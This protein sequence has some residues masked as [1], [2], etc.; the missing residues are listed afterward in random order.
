MV[1]AL[2]AVP[3]GSIEDLEKYKESLYE[4]VAC[5]SE[6]IGRI[7]QSDIVL[8][9]QEFDKEDQSA[10]KITALG[11]KKKKPLK[12]LQANGED[13]VEELKKEENKKKPK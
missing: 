10:A 1:A 4:L 7:V 13:D 8:D 6:K 11:P 2:N 12:D 5:R 9:S 3:P